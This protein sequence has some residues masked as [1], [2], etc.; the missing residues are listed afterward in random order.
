MQ[1]LSVVVLERDERAVLRGLGEMGAVHLVRAAAGPETAPQEPPDRSGDIARC[2]Q[3]LARIDKVASQLD[4]E[5]LPD[6]PEDLPELSLDEVDRRLA[7]LEKQTDETL[8]RREEALRRWGKV[9]TLLDQVSAYEG[10]ELSFDQIG[11][12]SFLHFALGSL[13]EENLSGFEKEVGPNVVLLPLGEQG[14]RRR[15]VAVTSRKGRFALETELEKVGFARES[16]GRPDAGTMQDVLEEA[17]REKEQLSDE[18]TRPREAL[19]NLARE[20]APELAMLRAVV[21]VE[22][23]LLEAEQNFPRTDATV[24]IN[25]WIPAEDVPSV[26]R[27][28]QD[29][30]GG[31]CVVETEEADDVPEDE[32]PVLLRHPRLL[33]PF[34][35][36]VVGYG[37]PRY[38][39][40]E[41]TLFVA[42]TFLIMFGIMFGDMGH[43]GVLAVVGVGLWLMAGSQRLR[44]VGVLLV[45][46]GA[47]SIVFGL[48]Y[49]ELF[50]FH[51]PWGLWHNP[52][53]G[54][55]TAI[56]VD[57][58]VIGVGII[59]L[60]LILNIV[61]RFR[62]GDL[63]GGFLDKFGVVGAVFYWGVLALGIR[64]VV[65]EE[66]SLHWLEIVLLV[67]LP[68]LALTL[69]EPIALVLARRAGREHHAG[70][71][72]M[73][74][75]ESAI[76]MFEGVLGYMANTISFV[77]LAAYAMS[78]AAILAA[79][80]LMA[81][82]V[83]KMVGGGHLGST[84]WV[85]VFVVGNILTILLE[86]IIATVQAI[87]LEY[88]EFFG[89]FF[90]GGG[91]AFVPFR[92]SSEKGESSPQGK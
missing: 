43:G 68:L 35:M 4:L 38:R 42:V 7:P 53:E 55:T 62:R 18:L 58:V 25:G 63:V 27:R 1:R 34:E 14:G 65:S 76:E 79:T 30:V 8:Q 39:E 72:V 89:K 48:V 31:R 23:K 44:D 47:S 32:V 21:R 9:T 12:F 15:L 81:R 40:L 22:R 70:N 51:V 92:L 80:F 57:A 45:F 90:A 3:L 41:P 60:G 10:L 64:F 11:R 52:L 71:I 69:K 2:D 83:E 66:K 73:A 75:L 78:H 77:R 91:R 87:R 82:E 86:G 54:D 29:L 33:R 46:A 5:E 6:P 74:F 26:R 28:L 56:L 50:G 16:M 85:V 59:S 88:Y 20:T 61:N 37:L 19:A 13:P 17:R 49:G 24:L 67:I 36:L 84:L